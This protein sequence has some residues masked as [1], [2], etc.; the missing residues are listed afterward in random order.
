MLHVLEVRNRKKKKKIPGP[1]TPGLGAGAGDLGHCLGRNWGLVAKHGVLTTAQLLVHKHPVT[2]IKMKCYFFF[3]FFWKNFLKVL[4]PILIQFKSMRQEGLRAAMP[5]TLANQTP[6]KHSIPLR[7]ALENGLLMVAFKINWGLP[8][9]MDSLQG[10]W[11]G[12]RLVPSRLASCW[13]GGPLIKRGCLACSPHS[14]G[15]K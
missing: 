13:G 14:W 11:P 3:F 2:I 5:A 15:M 10:W 8:G 7:R 4:L 12:S 6:K 1:G 9:W